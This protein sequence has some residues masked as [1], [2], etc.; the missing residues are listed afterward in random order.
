MTDVEALQE[1]KV[2][3]Y[4]THMEGEESHHLSLHAVEGCEGTDQDGQERGSNRRSQT[5]TA[6]IASDYDF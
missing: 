3:L 2:G 5:K 6:Q 4:R 1:R